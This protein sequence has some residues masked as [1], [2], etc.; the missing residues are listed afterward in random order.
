MTDKVHQ[1][2]P[3]PQVKSKSLDTKW[4]KLIV[5]ARP[6]LSGIDY[7]EQDFARGI[8][9][10]VR[11]L[12]EG[13]MSIFDFVDTMIF[14]IRRGF[15]RAWY[16]A[17]REFGYKP[18]DMTV[19]EMRQLTGEINSQIPYIM[20]FANAIFENNRAS[21]GKINPLL[22]RAEMWSNNY[23]RIKG[24]ARLTIADNPKLQWVIGPT[25][26]HCSDCSRLNERV[27][28]AQTWQKYGLFPRSRDLE[29][30]GV[31]CLCE[32][33]PTDLPC[34]PG[35]PPSLASQPITGWLPF[36]SVGF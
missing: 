7:G 10:N 8:R 3:A 21:G 14:T 20:P 36:G 9:A 33:L 31:K 2:Q 24:I 32:F 16:E 34:T 19:D 26:M 30:N 23:Q 29:C 18:E 25:E 5:K 28:R 13:Y 12:W 27:Y 22:S 17:I 35:R 11:S 1:V 4:G 15:T 6:N